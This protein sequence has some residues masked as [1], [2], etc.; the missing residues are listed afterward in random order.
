VDSS[1]RPVPTASNL[2]H[3]GVSGAAKILGVGN[4]D[5]SSHESDKARQ[6]RLFSGLAMIL[7]QSTERAGIINVTAR[8]RG[9]KPARIQIR[10]KPGRRRLFV[11]A[12]D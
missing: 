9:L 12:K 6:R 10:A 2:L 3:V 8:S 1:G 11:D 5:P 4:G 7:V